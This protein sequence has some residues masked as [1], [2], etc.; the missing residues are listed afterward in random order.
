M[1]GIDAA[2]PASGAGLRALFFQPV[3]FVLHCQ[4]LLA[5]LP[6][7]P[8]GSAYGI[9]NYSGSDKRLGPFSALPGISPW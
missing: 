1:L 5:I 8:D 6:R 7:V 4:P 9:A 3:V 2:L